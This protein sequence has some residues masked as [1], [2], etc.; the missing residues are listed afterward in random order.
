M[1]Q[2]HTSFSALFNDASWDLFFAGGTYV[3]FLAPFNIT[4]GDGNPEPCGVRQL[5]ATSANQHLSIALLT[6]VDG[7][8][9]PL[10][11]TFKCEQAMGV[12]KHAATDSKMFAFQGDLV[13]GTQSYLIELWDNTF[14]LIPCTTVPDA[15]IVQALLAANLQPG[16]VGP[17][18]YGDTNTVTVRTCFVVPI[19]S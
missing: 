16:V 17:F 9:T 6:L 1:A 14:N 4:P 12:A 13:G 5:I 11:L 8:L 10:F 3:A 18:N 15:G 7:H 2:A 19:P